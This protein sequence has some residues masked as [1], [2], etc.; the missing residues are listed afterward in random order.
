VSKLTSS[1]DPVAEEAWMAKWA[2]M[3]G[4]PGM[5]SGY[6]FDED[7]CRDAFREAWS[8]AVLAG[9][10]KQP[11]VGV[12]AM[13]TMGNRILLGKSKKIEGPSNWVIPGGGMKRGEGVIECAKRE[14]LEEASLPIEVLGK[15]RP[16]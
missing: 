1:P 4:G 11:R 2:G 6:A 14:L 8:A 5:T 10:R 15:G 7:C 3:G 16:S 13:V 9:D 12:A